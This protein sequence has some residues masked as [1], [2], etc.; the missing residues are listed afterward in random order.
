MQNDMAF[1]MVVAAYAFIGVTMVMVAF[2]LYA[3][4]QAIHE[5]IFPTDA[6][7]IAKAAL[8][9]QKLGLHVRLVFAE[10]YAEA[11]RLGYAASKEFFTYWYEKQFGKNVWRQE[12]GFSEVFKAKL[13]AQ[14]H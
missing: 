1:L 5:C 11:Q 8:R 14:F 4:F 3:C 12:V 2:V 6:Q 10:A 7:R 9:S 13:L